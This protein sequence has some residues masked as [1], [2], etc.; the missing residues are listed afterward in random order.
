VFNTTSGAQ[1]GTLTNAGGGRYRATFQNL[2]SN[3]GSVTVRSSQGGE[4]TRTV[5][6]R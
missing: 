5:A 2:R 1:I 3:P 4:A 6:V